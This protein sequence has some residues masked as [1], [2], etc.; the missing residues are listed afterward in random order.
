MEVRAIG[1]SEQAAGLE[2]VGAHV[3]TL[4]CVALVDSGVAAV[5][6]GAQMRSGRRART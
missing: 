1:S 3:V 2:R 5:I 4:S 6:E